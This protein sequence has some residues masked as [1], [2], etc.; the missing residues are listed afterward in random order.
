MYVPQNNDWGLSC[1]ECKKQKNDI[2]I[3]GNSKGLCHACWR[4][5][6]WEHKII[7]CPRCERMKPMHAKGLCNGCYNSVFNIE[8]ILRGNKLK[9][10]KVDYETYKNATKICVLCGFDKVVDLHHL[11]MNHN[12]NSIENLTGLCPNHHK[13]V[14]HREFQKEVLQSLRDK[15]FKVPQGF[16]DDKLFKNVHTT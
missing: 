9:Y 15:G 2:R 16:K 5:L 13:M 14:H 3:K 11:D 12:N 8:N 7:K 1:I 6:V 4:R 10:H